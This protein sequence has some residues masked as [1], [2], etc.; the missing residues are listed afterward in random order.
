MANGM[1]ISPEALRLA[2]IELAGHGETLHGLQQLCRGAAQDA[3][4]GWVGFSAGA[5]AELLDNWS[6]AGTNHVA[7]IG[8]QSCQMHFAAAEFTW[9]AQRN[10]AALA[11]VDNCR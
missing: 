9:M 1:R 8:E 6:A 3:H 2:G 5:L 10:F 7:R 11:A 4:P